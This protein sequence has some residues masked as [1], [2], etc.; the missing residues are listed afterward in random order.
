MLLFGCMPTGQCWVAGLFSLCSWLSQGFYR[1][2][3]LV[4]LWLTST[5]FKLLRGKYMTL[6]VSVAWCHLAL[7]LLCHV[8][9]LCLPP[10]DGTATSPVCFIDGASQLRD[11]HAV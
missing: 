9:R 6:Y 7:A 1:G 4:D 11:L 8:V 5:A 10:I 2:M 3:F